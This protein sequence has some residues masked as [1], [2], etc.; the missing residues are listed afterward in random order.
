MTNMLLFA[1]TPGACEQW[2]GRGGGLSGDGEGE[3]HPEVSDPALGTPLESPGDPEAVPEARREQGGFFAPVVVPP[4]VTGS[5]F[6][7]FGSDAASY[8]ELFY[9]PPERPQGPAL[10]AAWAGRPPIEGECTS[11][12]WKPA[13]RV[14]LRRATSLFFVILRRRT[15]GDLCHGCATAEYRDAQA[16]NMLYGWW[17]FTA[18]VVNALTMIVNRDEYATRM[19][20]LDLPSTREPAVVT[21]TGRQTPRVARSAWTRLGTWVTLALATTVVT[22]L[23]VFVTGVVT[24]GSDQPKQE[25]VTAGSCVDLRGRVVSCD[26]PDA[27]YRVLSVVTDGDACGDAIVYRD[28]RPGGGRP[29]DGDGYPLDARVRVLRRRHL[30]A[31]ADRGPVA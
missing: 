28:T 18:L 16:H 5:A 15:S 22:A 9:R 31:T 14:E 19:R 24:A 30:T 12:G 7:P 20:Y 29:V 13:I 25:T 3:A 23:T 4:P 11:C 1:L 2:M 6:P 21:S 10:S 26:S 8:G 17:G 27:T